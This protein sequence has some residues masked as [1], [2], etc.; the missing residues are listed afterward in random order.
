MM[1]FYSN[2]CFIVNLMP[3][4][5]SGQPFRTMFYVSMHFCVLL[6][7]F[8]AFLVYI[9]C[10]LSVSLPGLANKDVHISNADV[11]QR[12]GLPL[13]SDILLHRRQSLFGHLARL[14]S[15][16]PANDALQLMVNSHEGKKP[17]TKWTRPPGR[18]RRTWLNHIQDA[19]AR[20]L[21]TIWRSE[22]A[23][24]HGGAQRSVRTSR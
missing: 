9:V 14:D 2:P 15:S 19:D 6:L 10:S 23:R 24:G 5:V 1:V 22:V 7:C 16:V 11:L 17:S 8:F 21:S 18:P 20:L 12:S 4:T 3:F 13:I